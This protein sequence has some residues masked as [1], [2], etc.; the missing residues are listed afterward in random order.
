MIQNMNYQ[1]KKRLIGRLF[2]KLFKGVQGICYGSSDFFDSQNI[3]NSIANK[4]HKIIDVFLPLKTIN[5][6]N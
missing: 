6:N 2:V 3:D 1:S 5:E 4:K